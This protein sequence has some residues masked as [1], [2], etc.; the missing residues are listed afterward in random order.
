M[1][2][3]SRSVHICRVVTVPLTFSTLL[4]TQLDAILD[5]GYALTLVSGNGPELKNLAAAQRA[6]VLKLAMQRRFSILSDFVST[7]RL[8]IFLMANTTHILHSSTPKAGLIASIAGCVSRAKIRIHTYTGQPWTEMR[9]P[10]R[11]IA[12]TCDRLIAQLCTH[13]YADSRSQRDFLISQKIVA[14]DKISVLTDGS[15]SGVDLTRFDGDKRLGIGTAPVRRELGIP[16]DAIVIVFLGRI[17]HDKGIRELISAFNSLE[18]REMPLAL[19]LVGNVDSVRMPLDTKVMAEIRNNPRIY[20]VGFSDTPERYLAASDI[21]CLPSYREGFGTV[22]IEAAAM[23]L[24]A[25]VTS[26]YGLT[27]AVLDHQTGLFCSPKS[28]ESLRAS[29]QEL[30]N[31]GNLRRVLGENGKIRARKHFDARI[32]NQAVIDEYRRLLRASE[33]S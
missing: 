4:K 14:A 26:V 2:S 21:F 19:L 29:L 5:A 18:S 25:V 31:D 16:A 11:F 13:L 22:A 33:D 12:R 27:D 8:A 24:P 9:G 32:V 3:R 28:A 10:S 6:R 1:D 30:I 7:V 23:G 17:T 20:A 15:I